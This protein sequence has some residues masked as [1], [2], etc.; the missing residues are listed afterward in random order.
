MAGEGSIGERE[1]VIR[2]EN[3]KLDSEDDGESWAGDSN[4]ACIG[5]L[6]C[7]M[8]SGNLIVYGLKIWH[9]ILYTISTRPITLPH[10]VQFSY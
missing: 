9:L 3:K 1:L 6:S 2:G 4:R 5:A 7:L 10:I 8:N